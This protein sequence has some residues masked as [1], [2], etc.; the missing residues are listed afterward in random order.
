MNN[1]FI[2]TSQTT[3][4]REQVLQDEP[5]NRGMMFGY[6]DLNPRANVEALRRQSEVIVSQIS[7]CTINICNNQHSPL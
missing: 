1:I 2:L 7:R 4:F 6:K 5:K 3:I